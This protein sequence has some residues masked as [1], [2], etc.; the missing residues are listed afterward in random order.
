MSIPSSSKRD[1]GN[2][3]TASGMPRLIRV[4]FS[5]LKID[6]VAMF[7]RRDRTAVQRPFIGSHEFGI[8]AIINN[9]ACGIINRTK[10]TAVCG[11][12]PH[13]RCEGKFDRFGRLAFGFQA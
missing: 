9:Y 11:H 7:R 13:I 12:R 6:P 3:I 4:C 8:A 1:S 5:K 10:D 2:P